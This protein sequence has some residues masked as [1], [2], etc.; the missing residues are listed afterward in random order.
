VKIN[1]HKYAPV[2]CAIFYL[3]STFLLFLFG[4]FEWPVNNTGLLVFF[5]VVCALGML[6]G[7]VFGA[8]ISV[9]L[10]QSFEWRLFFRF[11]CV[12]SILLVAPS[13]YAYTGKW[14]WEVFSLIGSQG[15]AYKQMLEALEL[16]QSGIR[17]YVSFVR[18]LTAPFVFCVIPFAV[19]RWKALNRVDV[20]LLA[21]HVLAVL[22]FSFMRGTDRETG[23]LVFT[24]LIAAYML[25]LR[26]NNFEH[27][28]RSVPIKKFFLC[29]LI[30]IALVVFI[31][32]KEARMG[33]TDSFCI[34]DGLVCSRPSAESDPFFLKVQFGLDMFSAYLS[35]GYYGLSLSL[36]EDFDSTYGVGHSSFLKSMYSRFSDGSVQNRTY[37]EKISDLGWDARYQWSTIFPWIASDVGFPS[38]PLVVFL[39]FF[40][41]GMA[42]TGSI[43]QKDDVSSVLFMLLAI[44]VVYIPANNQLAQTLDGY[45]TFLFWLI[46]F[47]FRVLKNRSMA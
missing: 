44:L 3:L 12:F 37:I 5:L 32:R 25:K 26:S 27:K 46:L 31:D 2:L 36:N 28:V 45:L 13:T 40:L 18:G 6:V 34:A 21:G 4:S 30:L 11:G 39:V 10:E 19:L 17:V 35:Q 47:F 7:F 15:I 22:I 24:L 41:W 8:E 23:D 42:W 43:R 16:D 33:G 29:I 20:A 1:L 14:P 9:S 38:V